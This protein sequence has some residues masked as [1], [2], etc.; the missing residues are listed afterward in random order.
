M[1]LLQQ[2]MNIHM[3]LRTLRRRG[4]GCRRTSSLA[5]FRAAS[6]HYGN[7]L[8]PPP[9]PAGLGTPPVGKRA[10]RAVLSRVHSEPGGFDGLL[11]EA[12]PL[13]SM[14]EE[15]ELENDFLANSCNSIGESDGQCR[16]PHL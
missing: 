8:A 9:G 14:E 3:T 11:Y 16:L 6:R 10:C 4:H 2:L 12:S 1:L 7:T 15:R 5:S 13:T